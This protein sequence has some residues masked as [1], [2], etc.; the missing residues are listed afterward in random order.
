MTDNILQEWT[1]T[2]ENGANILLT[3]LSFDIED[4]S[5]CDYD[6]VEVT[7]GDY[8]ERFC[9]ND[10]PGPFTSCGSSITIK[11]QS[12]G[13]VTEAGF[14]AEWEELTTSTPCSTN[15]DNPSSGTPDNLDLDQ[16]EPSFIHTMHQ[17]YHPYHVS[18]N[19]VIIAGVDA[20]SR[21]W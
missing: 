21:K 16:V 20:C 19:I 8:S 2:S 7:Y 6:W 3:F 9:G 15:R 12:D 18:I 14:R 13:S 11:F 5:S 17:L 4:D 1:L 10:L